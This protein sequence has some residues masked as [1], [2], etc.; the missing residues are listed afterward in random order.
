MLQHLSA[1]ALDIRRAI[2][3]ALAHPFVLTPQP[4]DP[5][6]ASWS[7]PRAATDARGS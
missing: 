4:A 7:R 5:A 2:G 1:A 3:D 6:R